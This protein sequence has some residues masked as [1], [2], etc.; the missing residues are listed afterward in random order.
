MPW[1][2]LCPDMLG[3]TLSDAISR[4]SLR[5]IDPCN[6]QKA[7]PTPTD[8]AMNI[9]GVIWAFSFAETLSMDF[10]WAARKI[11]LEIGREIDQQQKSAL[12]GEVGNGRL[13]ESFRDF[14]VPYVQLDLS[15][16]LVVYKPPGW[17]VD[18]MALHHAKPNQLSRHLQRCSVRFLP[19]M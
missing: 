11:L 10:Y 7:A 19:A 9:V 12:S 14:G 15:D 16:R 5:F 13:R 3:R 1:A 6:V 4:A 2:C 8:F 18:T 17:E